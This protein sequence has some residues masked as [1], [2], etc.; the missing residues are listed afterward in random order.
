MKKYFES[1]AA[2]QVAHS[3]FGDLFGKKKNE[4]ID[5]LIKG[6]NCEITAS[7]ID[8]NPDAMCRS[9]FSNVRA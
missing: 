1:A 6:K 3:R 5:C 7:H 4:L 2:L 9:D 8:I